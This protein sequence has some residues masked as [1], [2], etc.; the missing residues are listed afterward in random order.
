MQSR[1]RGVQGG[2]TAVQRLT[3]HNRWLI[4]LRK[5]VPGQGV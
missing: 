1:S 5:G 4:N 3:G 2:R